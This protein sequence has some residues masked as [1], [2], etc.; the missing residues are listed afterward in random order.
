MK[1]KNPFP[2]FK[3]LTVQLE[4]QLRKYINKFSLVTTLSQGYAQRM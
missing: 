3:V 2:V 1:K 4:K